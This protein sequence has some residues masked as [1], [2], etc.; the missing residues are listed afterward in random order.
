MARLLLGG[1]CC[2]EDNFVNRAQGRRTAAVSRP[3]QAAVCALKQVPNGLRPSATHH[4]AGSKSPQD[5]LHSSWR[6]SKYRPTT[7]RTT[8]ASGAVEVA[9]HALNH[10]CLWRLA[11]SRPTEVPKNCLDTT[12]GQFI[13]RAPTMRSPRDRCAV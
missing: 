1:S 10:A 7:N 5:V 4:V 6:Q 8:T 13:Y 3:I 11:I 2:L 9:V 12:R